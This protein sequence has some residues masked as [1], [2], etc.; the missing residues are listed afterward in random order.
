MEQVKQISEFMPV[1]SFMH[2]G[3]EYLPKAGT[4]QVNIAHQLIDYGSEFV[5]GNSPHWVQNSE[6]YKGKLIA[7][8]TG[9]FI[10]DQLEE[11]TNR[12]VS[13]A[14][15][16]SVDYDDNVASWLA[17]GE[18][19]KLRND[20]CFERAKAQGLTKLKLRL[21]YDPIATT[22]GN[23]TVT[24][25]ASSAVQKAVEARLDWQKTLAGLIN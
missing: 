25:K 10:F 22:G 13:I 11:E 15:T 3:A 16:I 14:A 8:S 4:D 19:C 20:D 24:K 17:L 5:I 18:S 1:F 9:N 2:A 21:S 7:Y 23:R 6:A 12:G